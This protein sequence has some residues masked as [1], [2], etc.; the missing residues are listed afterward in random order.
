ML[1]MEDQCMSIYSYDITRNS[2]MISTTRLF[3]PGWLNNSYQWLAN[4]C[5]EIFPPLC[6][7][8]S[9]EKEEIGNG[10]R[11]SHPC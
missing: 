10:L 3:P 6:Y 2:C 9:L 5:W 4:Y 11:N 7:S 1:G 8:A